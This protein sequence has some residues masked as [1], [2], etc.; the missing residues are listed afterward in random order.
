MGYIY[1]QWDIH[2]YI[3]FAFFNSS[4]F[5]MVFFLPLMMIITMMMIT[6]MMITMMMMMIRIAMF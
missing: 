2:I 6:M 4:G 5:L 1:I 3:Q